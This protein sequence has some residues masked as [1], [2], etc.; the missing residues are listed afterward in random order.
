MEWLRDNH[1][2]KFG[3]GGFSKTVGTGRKATYYLAESRYNMKLH[4]EYQK[5]LIAK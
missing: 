4:R 3:Y 1:N 5:N 2:V